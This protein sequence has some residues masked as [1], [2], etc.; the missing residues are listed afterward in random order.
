MELAM[1]H[2]QKSDRDSSAAPAARPQGPVELDPALFAR[3]SGG[4]PRNGWT[5]ATIGVDVT[6]ASETDAAPRNGWL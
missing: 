1:Q 6:V 4:A 5:S 2:D 3:V